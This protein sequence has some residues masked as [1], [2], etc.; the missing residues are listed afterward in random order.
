LK[1]HPPPPIPHSPPIRVGDLPMNGR[2]RPV[3]DILNKLPH[4]V[5]MDVIHKVG[6]TL[7]VA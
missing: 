4:R 3:G 6:I 5:E 1:A 7:I 2:K